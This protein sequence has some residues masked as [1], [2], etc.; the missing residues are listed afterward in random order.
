M[1]QHALIPI[2]HDI[3]VFS[4]I[5]LHDLLVMKEAF[6]NQCPWGWNKKI[7]PD[8]HGPLQNSGVVFLCH[9]MANIKEQHHR[10]LWRN[11][12]KTLLCP[13]LHP[14]LHSPSARTENNAGNKKNKPSTLT[15]FNLS[16]MWL[17]RQV[18]E[19]WIY[20]RFK[21]LPPSGVKT[22]SCWLRDLWLSP[23]VVSA[24]PDDQRGSALNTVSPYC[25]P[26]NIS[27]HSALTSNLIWLRCRSLTLSRDRFSSNT[28]HKW[29]FYKLYKWNPFHFS[30]SRLL[31]EGRGWCQFAELSSHL[32]GQAD[33]PST[34]AEP[35]HHPPPSSG[36]LLSSKNTICCYSG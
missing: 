6:N 16:L 4:D 14:L 23:V 20:K 9:N 32:R 35:S 29:I 13:L 19:D 31:H 1:P 11:K 36:S 21:H 10:H 33:S 3:S 22:H 15:L 12:T 26:H 24:F 28:A 8:T 18:S 30:F 5:V 2:Y 27:S 17:L 25:H 7:T 34:P